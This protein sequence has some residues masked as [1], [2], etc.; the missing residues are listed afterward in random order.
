MFT[1]YHQS[2]VVFFRELA[3]T[4]AQLASQVDSAKEKVKARIEELDEEIQMLKEL[5][6]KAKLF[7]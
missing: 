5:E 1:F 7:K 4:F 2:F 3:S 6:A